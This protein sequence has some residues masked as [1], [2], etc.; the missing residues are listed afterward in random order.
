[1]WTPG[2][3]EGAPCR[4]RSRLA[5]PGSNNAQAVVME[6]SSVS[7]PQPFC[8]AVSVSWCIMFLILTILIA[9]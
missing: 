1:M 7:L 4:E 2:R 8:F 5:A 3:R 6:G 9:N